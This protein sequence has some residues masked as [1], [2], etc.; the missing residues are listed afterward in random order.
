[1]LAPYPERDE[2]RHEAAL[3]DIDREG[4]V[5]KQNRLR[6]GEKGW[7]LKPH[8]YDGSVDWTTPDVRE[9]RRK[10]RQRR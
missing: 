1:M 6:G 3:G 7:A 9:E 4:H 2:T 8:L 10:A 5:Q